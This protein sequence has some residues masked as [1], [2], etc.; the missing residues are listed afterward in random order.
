MHKRPKE[1]NYPPQKTTFPITGKGYH[2]GHKSVSLFFVHVSCQPS[3][4]LCTAA[5]THQTT[6]LSHRSRKTLFF[7]EKNAHKV[8]MYTLSRIVRSN[9]TVTSNRKKNN[10]CFVI[11][12]RQGGFLNVGLLYGHVATKKAVH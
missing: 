11:G 10:I 8:L 12:V 4:K 7:Y 6:N 9:P 5:S 2:S 3:L 1:S